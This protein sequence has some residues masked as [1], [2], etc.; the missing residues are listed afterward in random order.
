MH[1]AQK[2]Q[3]RRHGM[4]R[5]GQQAIGLPGFSSA[6]EMRP[7]ENPERAADPIASTLALARGRWEREE[8]DRL[9]KAKTQWSARSEKR[10]AISRIGA[11][12]AESAREQMRR[13]LEKVEDS[14]AAR[15]FELAE[16]R[17]AIE[18]E[19]VR[20]SQSPIAAQAQKAARDLQAE[21][22]TKIGL[23]LVRDLSWTTLLA[24]IA[25]LAAQRAT[26]IAASVWRHETGSQSV[27]KP[28]LQ[29]TGIMNGN[30]PHAV[31][32]VPLVR[33]RMQ[34]SGRARVESTL[35]KGVR[36]A[37]LARRGKWL[38]V[39]GPAGAAQEGWVSVSALEN[40]P[41]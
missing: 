15:T 41:P 9:A 23:R 2:L 39:R 5:V 36:V 31:V 4:I 29:Q 7:P 1:P 8:A 34:P 40:S 30:M 19:R 10:L 35:P 28:L 33:L 17:I 11:Q 22:R 13:R 12:R 37:L 3:A 24:A 32:I 27:V 18:Q 20:W 14:L 25:I 21:R 38:L 16:A 6:E 26:P